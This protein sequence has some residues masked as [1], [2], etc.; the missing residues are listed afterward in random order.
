MKKYVSHQ[1]MIGPK[2]P[3]DQMHAASQALHSMGPLHAALLSQLY[4][5][6]YLHITAALLSRQ[7]EEK[8]DFMIQPAKGHTAQGDISKT[9][10]AMLCLS[11]PGSFVFLA[12]AWLR[13]IG[14]S[15]CKPQLRKQASI[16]LAQQIDHWI[17]FAPC[18]T[19]ALVSHQYLRILCLGHG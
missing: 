4:C 2:C 3:L 7:E 16:L 11:S 6:L 8:K 18:V 10:H 1:G 19:S 14:R 5:A 17:L 15:S 12:T 13:K 9:H